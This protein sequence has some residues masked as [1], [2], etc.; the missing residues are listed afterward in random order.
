MQYVPLNLHLFEKSS[1]LLAYVSLC[2]C[3]QCMQLFTAHTY[4]PY[5][6]KYRRTDQAMEDNP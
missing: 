2:S 4:D 3:H 5:G 6:H 1:P